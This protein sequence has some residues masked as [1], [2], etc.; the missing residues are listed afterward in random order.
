MTYCITSIRDSELINTT[1]IV[2]PALR[3]K[4]NQNRKSSEDLSAAVIQYLIAVMK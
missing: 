1:T 4:D 3:K 2:R